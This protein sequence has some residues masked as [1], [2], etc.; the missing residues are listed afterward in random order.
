V[1]SAGDIVATVRHRSSLSPSPPLSGSSCHHRRIHVGPRE[2]GPHRCCP[3]PPPSSSR[4]VPPKPGGSRSH[5]RSAAPEP[6]VAAPAR[7]WPLPCTPSDP[8]RGRP[9]PS[10]PRGGGPVAVA[11]A[12]CLLH[13]ALDPPLPSWRQVYLQSTCNL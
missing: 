1:L 2:G 6:T 3:T 7:G 13:Q 5:L 8:L 11:V 4:S 10:D 9:P 12:P